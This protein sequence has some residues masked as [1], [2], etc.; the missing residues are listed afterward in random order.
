MSRLA[1][2]PAEGKIKR[3]GYRNAPLYTPGENL[4][5]QSEKK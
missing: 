4:N 5:E 2:L 1:E 3:T